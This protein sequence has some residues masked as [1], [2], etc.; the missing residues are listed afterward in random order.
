MAFRIGFFQKMITFASIMETEQLY[1]Y[2]K[3]CAGVTTDTR[4]CT[5]GSMFFALKGER[6]DGNAYARQALEA[7]CAYAVVDDPA[8]ADPAEP[9]LLLVDNVLRAL[10]LLARHHRRTLGTPI[11]GIT[12]TNG[13]TTTKEL[14]AAVLT[15]RFHTL[16]TQGNLNNA[17]GVPLT[18]LRL[19]ADHALAVV[20]MGASHPGDIRE[21]VEV[22]EPDYGI[23]TNV[24]RAHLQGFGS[25]EG[26]VRTKGEIYDWL[27]QRPKARIFLH[28]DNP[29][30]SALAGDLPATRYS[31]A[32]ALPATLE[33]PATPENPEYPEIPATPATPH[34]TPQPD[35]QGW[36]VSCDPF[37]T[38]TW[39]EKG[40]PDT[41]TVATHLVGRYNLDNALCAVAVGRHFGVDAD[42]ISAALAD[43]VP[44]NSRSQLIQ[45]A[46]HTLIVD[47]YNANPTS[48]LA[49][50]NNFADM[51]AAHKGVILGDMKELGAASASEHLALVQRL[52]ACG[53]EAV[54]LVGEQFSQALNAFCSSP[55]GTPLPTARTFASADE[56]IAALSASP[57]TATTVLVK[58]SNSM[59]L[60]TLVPYL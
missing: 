26:V 4:S 45:T 19:T 42:T 24:G 33:I 15:R 58:G 40:C 50:I 48:M 34:G 46:H 5:P 44:T 49:A 1:Q 22:A 57:L 28:A 37:L 20:E 6:F 39:R 17:I 56:V 41:H 18:L 2:Y 21:L 51:E 25:F 30:L 43:Y 38:F 12:G 32:A 10:Q 23:I 27:R 52:A 35:I 36:V 29:H 11:I 8:V 14:L 60:S 31:S 53:F 3:S 47:A 16:Y 59:H 9:R 13:K 7:G 54:W 55:D